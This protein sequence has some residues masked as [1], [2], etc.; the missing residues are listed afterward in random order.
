ML[1]IIRLECIRGESWIYSMGQ[2]NGLH[3]FSY[4]SAESEPIWM[5][6]GILWG[7]EPNVGGWPWQTLGA[8]RAVATVWEG[9]ESSEQNFWKYYRKGRY[10]KKRKNC[11][12]NVQVLRLQTVITPQ[13]LQMP[14]THD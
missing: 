7:F 8:I 13:W 14:K 6:F 4:N 11:S 2:R 1:I 5:K 12:Q 10:S 9:A 3:V